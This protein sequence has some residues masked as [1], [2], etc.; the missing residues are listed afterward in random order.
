VNVR[1]TRAR[2]APP[3]PALLLLLLAA[4]GTAGARMPIDL[5]HAE[6]LG[7]ADAPATIVV[8][9][10]FQCPHCKRAA[11]EVRR[12]IEEH[13][14][15]FVAYHKHFPLSYHPF[16]E[17]A[18]RAA[19]AARLQG[20]FWEMHDLLYAHAGELTADI[21]PRLAASLGLDV[22]R[23]ERDRRSPETAARVLADAA[24]GDAL[25]VDGTPFFFV[26]GTPVE[27]SWLVLL[28]RL[29]RRAGEGN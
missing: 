9:S 25:G 4:C 19:E 15:R 28:G 16:A 29:S 14:G 5:R 27:G 3:G 11:Y 23:F 8:F 21:W 12:L 17:D 10:D 22:P 20:A 2:P 24:E 13:P 18:A 7:D 1:R 26:D 6:P